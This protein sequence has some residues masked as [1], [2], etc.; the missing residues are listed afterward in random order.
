M[1]AASGAATWDLGT[2]AVMDAT[3]R[4]IAN[5]VFR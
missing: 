3:L 2:S 5:L 4:L 1:L